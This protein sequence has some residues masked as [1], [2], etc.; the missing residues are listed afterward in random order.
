MLLR[1]ETVSLDES[2][3]QRCEAAIPQLGDRAS[4]WEEGK[5]RSGE[6]GS[7]HPEKR[8]ERS[9]SIPVLQR[10]REKGDY[11]LENHGWPRSNLIA[12]GC[13]TEVCSEEVESGCALPNV[14]DNY[15]I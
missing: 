13:R 14:R 2:E 7:L 10:A 8:E 5:G 1:K 3:G 15:R 11:S 12:V 9:I 6:L 4:C